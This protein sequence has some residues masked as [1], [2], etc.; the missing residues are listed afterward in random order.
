MLT[1]YLPQVPDEMVSWSTGTALGRTAA[2]SMS[3]LREVH[4]REQMQ[5]KSRN[6]RLSFTLDLEDAATPVARAVADAAAVEAAARKEEFLGTALVLG[7]LQSEMLMP[8]A[9]LKVLQA[10][11]KRHF[12]GVFTA[13]GRDYL[14]L[15]NVWLVA[16][17]GNLNSSGSWLICARMLKLVLSQSAQ[18]FWD[19]SS[20]TA[21]ALLARQQAECET[22][23]TTLWDKVKAIVNSADALGAEEAEAA[24]T[25]GEGD[26]AAAGMELSQ[27]LDGQVDDGLMVDDLPASPTARRKAMHKRL[28][29]SAMRTRRGRNSLSWTEAHA[30]AGD[31]VTDCPITFSLFALKETLPPA[32]AVLSPDAQAHRVWTTILCIACLERLKS[33]WLWGDG[34]LCPAQEG[35]IV[36]AAEQWLVAH[37]AAHPALEKA[38]HKKRAAALSKKARLLTLAWQR[39]WLHRVRLLRREETRRFNLNSDQAERAGKSLVLA[40]MTRHETFRAFLA[41][42]GRY[43][44]W[45]RF[46]VTV[47]VVIC[48]L[49]MNIWMVRAPHCCASRCALTSLPP[50]SSS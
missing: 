1:Q 2:L 47:T 38:M 48:C 20:S 50:R 31:E 8:L 30:E 4:S 7:F 37:I 39:A 3:E 33:C 35:T 23:P 25:V 36:D 5:V 22:V 28:A 19:P 45:Q 27:R 16:F 9:Q 42:A 10:A 46:L 49:C 12:T 43:R 34:E 6:S 11:A 15:Q 21:F 32:L 44:R 29:V 14:F 40:A 41:P 18:G 24:D 13:A 26:A 17:D